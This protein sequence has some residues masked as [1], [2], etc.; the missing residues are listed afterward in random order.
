MTIDSSRQRS[1]V[2]VGNI[3]RLPNNRLV[4]VGETPHHPGEFILGF[5][6]E[7]G[8]DRFLRLSKEAM[9]ALVA[10][11]SDFRPGEGEPY[12]WEGNYQTV[13]KLIGIAGPDAPVASP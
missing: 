13:W 7:Q 2:P 8:E 10:L 12:P 3:A 1:S 4:F 11:H 9:D 6:N 5:R